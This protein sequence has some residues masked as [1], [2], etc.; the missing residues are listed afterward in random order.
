MAITL[1]LKRASEESG[2]SI[3]TLYYAMGNGQLHSIRVGRRRLIPMRALENFL[4]GGRKP[5]AKTRSA[6]RG[7]ADRGAVEGRP[8]REKA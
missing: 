5:K 8:Q 3:R 6:L 7:A 1:T 2:L 4:L